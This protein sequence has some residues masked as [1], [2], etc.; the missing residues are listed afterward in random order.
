FT[1]R[2]ALLEEINT[3]PE[4]AV[5]DHYCLKKDVPIGIAWMNEVRAHEKNV[6]SK[7]G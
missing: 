3:L 2:L 4:G 7:R 6:L 1:G 5:W